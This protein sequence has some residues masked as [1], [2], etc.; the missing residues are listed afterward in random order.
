MQGPTDVFSECAGPAGPCAGRVRLSHA[1]Q[2]E[3]WVSKDKDLS[4]NPVS[5]CVW[6]APSACTHRAHH[7]MSLW[8][9]ETPG[10]QPSSAP[11]PTL[12]T[13]VTAR[14]TQLLLIKSTED[15]IHPQHAPWAHSLT[16]GL[17][18]GVGSALSPTAPQDQELALTPQR[19][20]SSSGVLRGSRRQS[21][22]TLCSVGM[23][24][25]GPSARPDPRLAGS[26]CLG[27]S[28]H[29]GVLAHVPGV[30]DARPPLPCRDTNTRPRSRPRERHA[31]SLA[32][33]LNTSYISNTCL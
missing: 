24:S 21:V 10:G 9:E 4:F 15:T 32:F 26:A 3:V 16:P 19:A 17:G 18:W 28:L 8:C 14:A 33:S 25:Q 29:S 6:T 1:P 5:S 13:R 27:S 2:R 22:W 12:S 23:A 30:P 20:G 31:V 11:P 7:L